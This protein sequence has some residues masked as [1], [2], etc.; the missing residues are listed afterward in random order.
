ML[1]RYSAVR[2]LCASLLPMLHGLMFTDVFCAIACLF[3]ESHKTGYYDLALIGGCREKVTSCLGFSGA[4]ATERSFQREAQPLGRAHN[5]GACRRSYSE[6]YL[7]KPSQSTQRQ[8][9]T[10]ENLCCAPVNSVSLYWDHPRQPCRPAPLSGFL[11]I[12]CHVVICRL[13]Y[14][15]FLFCILHPDCRMPR[16]SKGKK[17][18]RLLR[19]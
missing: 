19:L 17:K 11:W 1:A 15:D 6:L 7:G 2:L 12:Y 16:A 8:R 14:A 18:G 3:F 5:F 4:K 9:S 13:R 10:A